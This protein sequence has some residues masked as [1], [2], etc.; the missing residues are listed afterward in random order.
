MADNWH[1]GN[2]A[3]EADEH[4]G[5]MLGHFM[6]EPG[7]ASIRATNALARLRLRPSRLAVLQA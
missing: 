1:V 5:W 3:D 2:A 7:G 4:R 6:N